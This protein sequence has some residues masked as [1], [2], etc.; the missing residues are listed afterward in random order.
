MIEVKQDDD[1]KKNFSSSQTVVVEQ[2]VICIV[3]GLV[4]Q[5]QDID[6]EE[7]IHHQDIDIIE[8]NIMKKVHCQW[9]ILTYD[10]MPMIG[11]R[12]NKIY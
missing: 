6:Q 12:E 4:D 11:S 7:F 9:K 3:Y 2:R 5:D 8:D 1:Q 10:D